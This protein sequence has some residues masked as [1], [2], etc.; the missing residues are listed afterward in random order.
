MAVTPPGFSTSTFRHGGKERTVFG[1]GSGP[2]VLVI[3][4]MPGITPR[5][6]DFARRVA[7]LGFTALM[8]ELFGV[9]GRAPS[10]GAY[11]RT[12]LQVCVSREFSLLAMKRNS[13]VT[14][15]LRALARH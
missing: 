12:T 15:W 1:T 9:T 5:V 6:A 13:P 8:P 3:A 2:A 7:G 4:E 14:D 10:G 11:L